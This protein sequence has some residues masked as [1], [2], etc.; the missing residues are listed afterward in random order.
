[1]RPMQNVIN[2]FECARGL[3]GENVVRLLHDANLGVV[4][5]RIAAV[6]AKLGVADVVALGAQAEVIF[7]LNQRSGKTRGV[8]AGGPQHVERESLRGL[9]P[10]PWETAK[11]IDEALQGRRE[12]RHAYLNKPGL[13]QARRQAEP[14]Q[15]ARRLALRFFVDLLGRFIAGGQ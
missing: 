7:D 10:D 1:N 14:A 2:A 4:A 11:L 15:K 3:D 5:M 6:R 9:L 8:V 12:I 13:Q